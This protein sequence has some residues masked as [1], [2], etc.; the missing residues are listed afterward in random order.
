MR[1]EACEGSARWNPEEFTTIRIESKARKNSHGRAIAYDLVPQRVGALRQLQPEGGSYTA[2]LD[3]I[4]YDFWVTRAESGNTSYMDVPRYAAERRPLA[5]HPT[6]IWH[7]APMVHAPRGEDFDVRDGNTS[8]GGV[9]ITF[10][11]DMWNLGGLVSFWLCEHNDGRYWIFSL[12]GMAL[13]LALF[14]VLNLATF[15]LLP[16]T[17]HALFR[18]AAR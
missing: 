18:S 8:Y 3:F 10:G 9:A 17:I 15:A 11:L 2:N 7:C 13:S 16:M 12:P 14:S 5:G 6:T 4:N 1:S